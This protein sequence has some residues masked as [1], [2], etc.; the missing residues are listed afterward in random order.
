MS[1]QWHKKAGQGGEAQ[2]KAQMNARGMGRRTGVKER[3][4]GM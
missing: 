4:G 1:S 2:I 3:E